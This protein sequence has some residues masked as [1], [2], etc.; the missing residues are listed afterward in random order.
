[1]RVVVDVPGRLR[2]G[3]G[4]YAPV[5]QENTY[6][7]AEPPKNKSIRSFGKRVERSSK[8]SQIIPVPYFTNSEVQHVHPQLEDLLRNTCASVQ[9][10]I[11]MSWAI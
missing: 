4:D 7:V 11:D 5:A 10:M 9:C 3:P 1:M 2:C 8:L 6:F